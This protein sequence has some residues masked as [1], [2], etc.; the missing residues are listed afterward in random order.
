MS[1][2]SDTRDRVIKLE[3]EV[4]HLKEDIAEIKAKTAAMYDILNQ[5]KGL[6]LAGYL[7]IGSFGF[8]ISWIPTI[9]N[10]FVSKGA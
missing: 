10:F 5:A 9:Y 4:Q 8:A 1:L 3:A 7:I 2:E 6:R